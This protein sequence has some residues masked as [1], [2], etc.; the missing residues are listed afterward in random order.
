MGMMDSGRVGSCLVGARAEDKEIGGRGMVGRG[1]LG[2]ATVNQNNMYDMV[3][4]QGMG[5][6]GA[7]DCFSEKGNTDSTYN[8]AVPQHSKKK[9][10]VTSGSKKDDKAKRPRKLNKVMTKQSNAVELEVRIPDGKRKNNDECEE[11]HVGK[12]TKKEC[13]AHNAAP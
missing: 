2:A 4:T 9:T 10:R 13:R 7:I 12:K 3:T 1:M 8:K 11:R 5:G 6:A